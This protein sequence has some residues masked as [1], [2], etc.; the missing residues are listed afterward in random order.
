[1]CRDK[2]AGSRLRTEALG[3]ELNE[4]EK[5][6]EAENYDEVARRIISANRL[7]TIEQTYLPGLGPSSRL[8]GQEERTG[9]L[10]LG[11]TQTTDATHVE[12][13]PPTLLDG[14]AQGLAA[15]QWTLE[16]LKRTPAWGR[17]AP[18][19]QE[20]LERG[21][22]QQSARAVQER[23]RQAAEEFWRGNQPGQ[24]NRSARG[25]YARGRGT[26]R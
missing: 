7:T 8:Q 14:V 26:E 19:Q 5:A 2:C 11:R 6:K 23:Q 15:G 1:M 12:M 24:L 9:F 13:A 4:L 3:Q 22:G 17:L 21:F 16:D 18:Q 25:D 20:L 10:N